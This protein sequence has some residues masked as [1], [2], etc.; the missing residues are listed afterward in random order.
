MYRQRAI[1][2]LKLVSLEH[3]MHHKPREMSGGEMQRAAIARALLAQ[4]RVLFADEPTGNLDEATGDAV[5]K[6]L[7][8]LVAEEDKSLVLVTHNP[9][10]AARTDRAL[11]LH[12]GKLSQV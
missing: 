5:M 3:R 6:L 11:R 8:E 4:P 12:L 9:D 2:L 10:Y 7:L 1:E